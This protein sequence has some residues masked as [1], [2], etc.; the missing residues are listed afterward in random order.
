[1]IGESEIEDFK[2]SIL[3]RRLD[4]SDFELTKH[5]EPM[6]GVGVQPIKGNVT[7]KRKSSGKHKTYKAGHLS[8]WPAEFDQDLKRGIFD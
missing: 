6:R 1:M 5:E 2:N 3:S 8:S 4:Q 7:I